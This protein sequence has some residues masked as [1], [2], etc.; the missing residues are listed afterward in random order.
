MRIRNVCLTSADDSA[1][2][3]SDNIHDVSELDVE[4]Y[5]SK[6]ECFVGTMRLFRLAALEFEPGKMKIFTIYRV[7]SGEVSY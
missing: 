1:H 2:I 5:N 7:K 4:H 6:E 3:L